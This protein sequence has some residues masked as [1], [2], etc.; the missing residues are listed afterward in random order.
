MKVGEL[1]ERTGVSVRTLHHY[2]EIG[3]LPPARRTPAR[4]RL[5]GQSELR[6]LQAILFLRET[7]LSLEEIQEVLD[8]PAFSLARAVELQLGH[9]EEEL[10]R[11]A[12][13]RGRLRRLRRR[14]K[15]TSVSGRAGLGT[16]EIFE[17]ARLTAQVDRHFSAEQLR[18]LDRRADE[19]GSAAIR[20][21][22]ARWR[23][24]LDALRDEWDRGTPVT[25]P[26]VTALAREARNLIEHFT[27]GDPELE[28]SV[29]EMYRA[30]GPERILGSRGLNVDGELWAYLQRALG[31]LPGTGEGGSTG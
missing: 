18:D 10:R 23:E 25:D 15:A 14:L 7:G 24:L 17:I 27:G 16:G 29:R 1:A 3:L 31:T 9:V 21:A 11:H 2:D 28:G 26:G 20:R 19:L 4:H 22:E 12:E 6:R 8:E 5:Y 30:E 13:L